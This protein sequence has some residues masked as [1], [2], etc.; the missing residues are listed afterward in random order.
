MIFI[1]DIENTF[2]KMDKKKKPVQTNVKR[3][4]FKHQHK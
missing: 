3:K 1:L 2:I 4:Q